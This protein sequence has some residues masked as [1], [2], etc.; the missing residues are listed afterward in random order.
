MMARLTRLESVARSS[1]LRWELSTRSA[2]G[3]PC[4][5]RLTRP[6]MKAP[7]WELLTPLEKPW[8]RRS[9]MATPA[10]TPATGS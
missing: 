4:L 8:P 1:V 7:R 6:V 9:G 10:A 2:S 3:A 5:V